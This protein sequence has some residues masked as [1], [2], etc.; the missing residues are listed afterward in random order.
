M[1]A[2]GPTQD[3][4]PSITVTYA[5]RNNNNDDNNDDGGVSKRISGGAVRK[6]SLPA[7]VTRPSQTEILITTYDGRWIIMFLVKTVS[8]S[9]SL[10]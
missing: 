9:R 8:R 4:E 2:T 10:Q 6:L 1:E 5:N 7:T 3:M